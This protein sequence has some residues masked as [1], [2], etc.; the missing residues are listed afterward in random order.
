MID[1]IRQKTGASI[2]RVCQVLDLPRSSYHAAVRPTATRMDDQ[3]LGDRIEVVFREHRC[4]YGYRRIEDELRDLGL[5]CRPARSEP[6]HEGT[7]TSCA[8][9]QKLHPPDQ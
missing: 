3:M 9:T 8:S 1:S 4:R 6:T 5:A 7:G 2:R